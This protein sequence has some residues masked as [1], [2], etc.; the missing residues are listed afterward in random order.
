[1]AEW[2]YLPQTDLFI[3]LP[4]IVKQG[5]FTININIISI[6]IFFFYYYYNVK[7]GKQKL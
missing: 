6:L 3:D 1:M 2:H 4:T 5:Q 7:L